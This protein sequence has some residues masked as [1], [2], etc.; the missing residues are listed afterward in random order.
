M[1]ARY[2]SVKFI[3][4][5]QPAQLLYIFFSCAGSIVE[6]KNK[7]KTRQYTA[8]YSIGI[9]RREESHPQVRTTGMAWQC[10]KKH[11][12]IVWGNQ[13]P[14]E[15][16]NLYP[17]YFL[18]TP[19]EKALDQYLYL[20]THSHTIENNKRCTKGGGGGL[21][22]QCLNIFFIL[23]ITKPRQAYLFFFKL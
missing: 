2:S 19:S 11:Q 6:T 20:H 9:Q 4:L 13:R 23:I 22:P 10:W 8:K 3:T 17:L 15:Y 14:S 21:G 5:K 12:R 1:Y 16:S 18:N 7:V